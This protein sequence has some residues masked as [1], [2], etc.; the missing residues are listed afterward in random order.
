MLICNEAQRAEAI[1]KLKSF[2]LKKPIEV[3]SRIYKLTRNNA[4]NRLLYKWYAEIAKQS[5]NGIEHERNTLK[6]R[7]GCQILCQNDKNEHF[8][9]FYEKLINIYNY[10]QCVDSMSFIS[11]SSLMNMREFTDY[12]KQIECY[13]INHG[14]Y[15]TKPDE[16]NQ[17]MGKK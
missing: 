12:L 9:D 7:Y 13:A 2:K 8:R 3:I 6:F 1:E 17:A 5:G 15:L 14:Y 16:Y 10:E 11:V 4:Q